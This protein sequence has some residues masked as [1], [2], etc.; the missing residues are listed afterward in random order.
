[1]ATMISLLHFGSNVTVTPS[2]TASARELQQ[3]QKIKK[4]KFRLA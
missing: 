3:F 2:V 4:Y 1:M